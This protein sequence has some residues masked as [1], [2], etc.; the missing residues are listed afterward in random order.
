MGNLKELLNSKLEPTDALI[1]YKS[2]SSFKGAY[3]EHR[4][5]RDGKMESGNPLQVSVLAKMMKSVDRYAHDTTKM[6]SLHGEIPT[7]LL[8]ASSNLDTYRMVWY[9]KPER[10]RLFF[11]ESLDIPDGEMWVPGLVYSTDGKGLRV[12]AFKGPKPKHVLYRAPFFNVDEH[13]CLG[14]AKVDKPTVM[15]YQNW[16]DYWEKMFWLSEF[17]HLL[18]GN[19]IKGN[20]STLTKDLIATGNKFPMDELKKANT[21]LKKLFE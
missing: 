21:T 9:R 17:V 5:I 20:L 6:S 18:G 16:I 12:F 2:N 15:T 3:V 11:A 14:N 4:K 8:Y 10:R 1:F 19:P 13:V 7:N